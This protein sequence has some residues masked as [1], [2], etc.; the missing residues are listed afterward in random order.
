[1]Y[2]LST[3]ENTLADLQKEITCG[4]CQGVYEKAK[5]LPCNHYY[6]LSCIEKVAARSRSLGEPFCCP[7]CRN[8]TIL[9]PG[10]T[11][12]LQPAFF[13]ERLKDLYGRMAKVEGKIETVCEQCGA[14]AKC[15]A[16]CTQ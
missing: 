8:E 9:P 11:G 16:F 1:M 15:T 13:L 12:E 10:G 4:V 7:E 6:C 2:F 5:L 14:A 3:R